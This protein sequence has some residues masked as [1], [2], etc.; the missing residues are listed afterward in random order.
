MSQLFYAITTIKLQ[1]CNT[2]T[3]SKATLYN[4]LKHFQLQYSH[5]SHHVI[6]YKT[7]PYLNFNCLDTSPSV[8][9]WKNN[10][11]VQ[12][13]TEPEWLSLWNVLNFSVTQ[14][15]LMLTS[16]ITDI[17]Y[18]TITASQ[19]MTLQYYRN[20]GMYKKW[21]QRLTSVVPRSFLLVSCRKLTGSSAWTRTDFFSRLC[22]YYSIVDWVKEF[23]P[24]NVSHKGHNQSCMPA[25]DDIFPAIIT[26]L[27]LL[28]HWPWGRLKITIQ[29]RQTQDQ[30][31]M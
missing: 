9:E 11:S 5:H 12:L 7:L 2:E 8:D 24:L 14:Y 25:M 19:V 15:G 21:I 23:W 4:F 1:I 28:L 20:V 10:H 27:S 17:Y 18:V 6:T 31:F 22:T 3:K 29:D 13:C 16:I 26:A 30:C